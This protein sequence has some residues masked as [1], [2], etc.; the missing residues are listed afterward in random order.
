MVHA[1]QLM[2]SGGVGWMLMFLGLA[3][4]LDATATYGNNCILTISH[5]CDVLESYRIPL[6][7]QRGRTGLR[8]I[9]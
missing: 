9:H 4:M 6:E 3:H 7:F 1:T 8:K 5:V 2:L